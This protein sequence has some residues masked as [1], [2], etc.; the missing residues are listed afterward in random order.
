MS[1]QG[2]DP[3]GLIEDEAA[4]IHVY[5]QETHF[6]RVLNQHLRGTDRSKIE[7]YKPYA[8]R[9]QRCDA[10]LTPA[11]FC[12]SRNRF[13]KLLVT[14]LLKIPAS[15]LHLYRGVTKELSQLSQKFEKGKHVVWWPVTSTASSISV[16]E[17]PQFMGKTGTRCM[18][19]I[20]A[21]TARDIQ[22]YSAMG[23]K[24]CE[25]VLMPGTC[26]KVE[27][28]MDA[29]SDLTM[30]QLKEDPLMK[31]LQ[32]TLPPSPLPS[33]SSSALS[34]GQGVGVAP[35]SAASKPAAVSAAAGVSPALPGTKY[36]KQVSSPNTPLFHPSHTSSASCS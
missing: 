20:A 13:L 36:V 19:V 15:T 35:H 25:Y 28:I 33:P 26:F 6:Y 12:L 3:H 34:A 29:G 11:P 31:L 10:T 16:L 4:S 30:V 1:L 7:P 8:A 9:R 23:S 14:A 5:T 22:R 17:N 2:A 27:D 18:F 21:V 24:E 32:F